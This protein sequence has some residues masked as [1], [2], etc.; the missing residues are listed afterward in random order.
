M[1]FHHFII[2]HG[3]TM[4]IIGGCMELQWRTISYEIFQDFIIGSIHHK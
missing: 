3:F 1:K 4:I 2:F